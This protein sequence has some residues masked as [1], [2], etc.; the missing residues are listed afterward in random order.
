VGVVSLID[1]GAVG[2]KEFFDSRPERVFEKVPIPSYL[3][4][5]VS[6]FQLPNSWGGP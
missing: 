2:F 4:D 1:K 6:P 5:H 3:T